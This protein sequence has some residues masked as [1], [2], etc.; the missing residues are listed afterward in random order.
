MALSFPIV[1]IFF[2]VRGDD[3]KYF[4]GLADYKVVGK[5]VLV[6]GR[7]CLHLEKKGNQGRG[8]SFDLDQERGY[9]V[10][11]KTIEQNGIV[12][13]ELTVDNAADP[14]VGWLPR[15][16][17][18]SI[19]GDRDPKARRRASD[20]APNAAGVSVQTAAGEQSRILG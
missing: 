4:Q 3:P 17:E 13:W 15:S 18:Y 2:A 19:R 10:V 20:Q 14:T 5:D 6:G 11:R 9:L 16:W 1:P 12:T 8:E 7:P